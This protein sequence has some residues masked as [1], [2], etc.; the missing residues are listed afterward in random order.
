MRLVKYSVAASLDGFI[1]G[2]NGEHEWII[3]DPSIDFRALF[4]E[5]DTVLMGRRTFEVAQGRGGGWPGMNTVV[6]SRTLRAA[7]HPGVTIVGEGAA[8]HVARLKSEPGKNIWLMGGGGLF[9]S[10]LDEGQ[11][12]VVDVALVPVMLGQ[13]IPLIQPGAARPPLRLKSTKTYP[14]GI[15]GLSYE[16]GAAPRSGARRSKGSARKAR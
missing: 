2:P 4:A 16:V 7:D 1:A 3:M 9:R 14:S 15:V 8:E 11:V 5:F 13:G 10:L 12:D 6:F